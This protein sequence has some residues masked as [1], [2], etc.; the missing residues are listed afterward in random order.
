MTQDPSGLLERVPELRPL[1]DDARVAAAV[2]RGDPFVVYRALVI[3]RLTGRLRRH[4][5][6]VKNL[7][8]NRRLF[9]KPMKSGS[10]PFL[11]TFNGF[12]ATLL[13]AAENDGTTHIA[14]HFAVGLF[15]LPLFPFGAYVVAPGQGSALRRSW[16]LFARVPLTLGAWLWQ[17]TLSLAALAAILYAGYGAFHATRNHTVHVL[18][19]LPEPI[20]VTMGKATLDIPPGGR[21]VADLP[22]GVV[23]AKATL[24]SGLEVDQQQIRVK[25]GGQ[26][27]VWNVAGAAPL[28]VAS[29]E[30]TTGKSNAAAHKPPPPVFY[31]GQPV[32]SVSDVDFRFVEPPSSVSMSGKSPMVVRKL[33]TTAPTHGKNGIDLCASYLLGTGKVKEAV[34]LLELSGR[35]SGWSSETV[36]ALLAAS[37]A[38]DPDRA[39]PLAEEALKAKPDSVLLHR[40]YQTMASYRM[41]EADLVARYRARAEAAPGSA[42]A[43]YLHARLLR[44]PD[45]LQAIR[46]ASARFPD[47]AD[48]LRLLV[49]AEASSGHWKQAQDAWQRLAK[50]APEHAGDVVDDGVIALVALGQVPEARVRLQHGFDGWD[51]SAQARAA[52]LDAR[53]GSLSQANDGE[54]LVKKV[55]GSTQ[56]AVLRVRAGLPGALEGS[57]TSALERFQRAVIRDPS[58]VP[59]L[60]ASLEV[61]DVARLSEAEWGLAWCEC[62]RLGNQACRRNLE[63]S[64]RETAYELAGVAA[65]V[66]GEASSLEALTLDPTLRAAALVTR[67]RLSSLGSQERAQLVADARRTDWVHEQITDALPAW[68]RTAAH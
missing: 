39:L 37:W 23:P 59:S 41:P 7:V 16:R 11:G 35:L 44:G 25:S 24:A 20:H 31:C 18:N 51:P 1:C 40:V 66:R 8:G 65:F 54:R 27:L 26:T 56:D 5:D 14:T 36:P 28:V 62:A 15:V 17:R 29:I 9:A 30:Y 61:G 43:Q 50:L 47:S 12:G 13:G 2:E 33:L 49:H 67:S 19:G 57:P 52:V 3:G 68:T 60:A 53:L 21:Q 38:L 34:S 22:V 10:G 63:R 32:V 42:D 55:E 4:R 45:G 58:L 6:V 48:L 46:A 64:L